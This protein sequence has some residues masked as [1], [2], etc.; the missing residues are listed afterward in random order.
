MRTT[1]NIDDDVL[2]AAK[3][4]SHSTGKSLGAVLSELARRGLQPRESAEG[5]S[6]VRDR[7]IPVFRVSSESPVV[8]PEQIKEALDEGW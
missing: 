7:G 5:H 2:N 8:T 6:L 3:S 4:L 1:V